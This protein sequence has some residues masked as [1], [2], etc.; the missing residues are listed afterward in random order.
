MD[1]ETARYRRFL[2]DGWMIR[3]LGLFQPMMREF[4]EM[5]Y[6]HSTPVNLSD[7]KLV[8][9]LGPLRRT[10]YADGVQATLDG[11]RAHPFAPVVISA[12]PAR[13]RR[14]SRH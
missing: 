5:H 8:A 3:T 2:V 6:L 4:A 9:H 10:S 12:R 1:C 11:L 13:R 14:R 7:E